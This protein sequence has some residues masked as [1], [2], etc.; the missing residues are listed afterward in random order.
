M[1]VEHL[2]WLAKNPCY[3]QRFAMHMGKLCRDMPNKTVA[4]MERLHLVLVVHFF[5]ANSGSI[6][7]QINTH[8]FCAINLQLYNENLAS[9][10]IIQ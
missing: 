7:M 2:D 8:Y 9:S 3:T 4:E 6:W 5:N 1:H 10:V